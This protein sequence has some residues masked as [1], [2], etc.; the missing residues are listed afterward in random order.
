MRGW[1]FALAAVGIISAAVARGESPAVETGKTPIVGGATLGGY[2]DTSIAWAIATPKDAGA[3]AAFPNTIRL[4]GRLYDTPQRM[5]GFNLNAVSI[6]LDKRVTDED[7][8]VGYHVQ[9]LFGPD[10]PL[11]NSYSLASGSTEPAAL[12][13]AYVILRAPPWNGFEFRVGYFTSPLGYEVYDS[14]RN[15]NYSRSYGYFIEPK[16]HTGITVKYDFTEWCSVMA[17]VANSH[18][19]FIDAR[20]DNRTALTA[21]GVIELNGSAFGCR[22]LTLTLG[23]TGGH[24]DTSAPTDVSPRIHNFYAGARVPLYFSGLSLGIAYDYQA[25]YSAGV[26]AMFFFPAGPSST[27]ANAAG[28][29]LNYDIAKWQFRVRGEYASAT[30][31]NTILA[32]RGAFNSS[33]PL[34]GDSDDKF[35]G[36]T[37]TV[38]YR[39]WENVVSRF[40][41]RWDRDVAGGVP[42]FGTAAHPLRNSF[43]VALNV[44][45]V[46]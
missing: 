1:S 22:D 21:L 26:P 43:T 15:P 9:A 35:I 16:A 42:V 34:F 33:R 5:N 40:E 7:W 10:V 32:S 44:V 4:P 12:N 14:Y 20:A 11:R 17:G 39:F 18:S 41:F 8:S 6:E 2:V 30:A 36:V 45:Y 24:T 37:G 27:Y 13:E 46:F 25:N 31:G 38:G 29:Y 19:P 23:Y 28:I 3:A